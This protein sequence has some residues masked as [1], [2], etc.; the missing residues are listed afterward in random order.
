ML[1]L[2]LCTGFVGGPSALARSPLERARTLADASRVP[3]P[4]IPGGSQT[5]NYPEASRYVLLAHG[6]KRAD[7][8]VQLDALSGD[9]RR[10]GRA[11]VVAASV[12]FGDDSA[13]EEGGGE[14]RPPAS[15]DALLRRM[16][17]AEP[18][19]P[20]RI[21]P[22]ILGP[23]RALRAETPRLVREAAATCAAADVEVLPCLADVVDAE[24]ARA[25]SVGL[26]EQIERTIAEAGLTRP[27]VLV[28]DHGSADAAVAAVRRT[29]VADVARLL[30]SAVV[31]VEPAPMERPSSLARG[32]EADDPL[33]EE[34]LAGLCCADAAAVEVVVAMAFL[35]PGRHA[36][37][38]GDVAEIVARATAGRA[39]LRVHVS[40]LLGDSRAVRRVLARAVGV[41]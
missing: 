6:S 35:S 8:W 29:M 2:V 9:L 36:G 11:E 27:F 40:E 20:I 34:R 1:A 24:G 22:F 10:A 41:A 21:L 30:G 19:R 25:V 18:A 38:D 3:L 39:D 7:T 23:S 13:A 17:A 31:G 12:F 33:L 26:A 37:A 32:S 14:P 15:L 16:L 5:E 4:A 28:C